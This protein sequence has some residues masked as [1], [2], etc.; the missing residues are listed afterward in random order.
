[1]K[2]G[3]HGAV[4]LDCEVFCFFCNSLM[5][6]SFSMQRCFATSRLGLSS[7]RQA[8]SL[9]NGIFTFRV[10]SQAMIF[11]FWFWDKIIS[12]EALVSLVLCK[13]FF[14]ALNEIFRTFHLV[15]SFFFTTYEVKNFNHILRFVFQLKMSGISHCGPLALLERQPSRGHRL[16][17]VTPWEGEQFREDRKWG[18]GANERASWEAQQNA[19]NQI[20][21]ASV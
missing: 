4:S 16:V 14:P 13:N 21:H 19:E 15:T 18:G 5:F 8:S 6:L 10:R 12:V 1:M 3:H 2:A 11:F 7:Q 20:W 17:L 9:F